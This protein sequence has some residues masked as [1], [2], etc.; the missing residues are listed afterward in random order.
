[1]TKVSFQ[2][3]YGAYSHLACMALFPDAQALPCVTFADALYAVEKGEATAAVIPLENSAAGRVA[4]MHRLLPR[5]N[6]Y[7]TAE[8]YQPIHHAL[9]GVKG[10]KVEDVKTA[11]SHVQALTQCE[12]F[13]QDKE[14]MPVTAADTAGSAQ[15]VAQLGDK[16]CAAIASI[17]AAEAYGLEV[18]AEDIQDQSSNTT[19]FVVFCPQASNAAYSSN[20]AY[21]TS[22]LFRVRNV[23]AALYKALGGFATNNVNILKLESYMDPDFGNT[24]FYAEV[25]AHTEEE[26]CRNAL[27]E[28]GFFTHDIKVLGCY[29]AA[30]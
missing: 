22:M 1:M 29:P 8:H 2:G 26:P 20:A 12:K 17:M 11:M 16:S 28:L 9:L 3:V 19:R 18:L 7:I 30:R 15:K 4:D 14:I 6:L 21:K 5:T 13:L 23:P 25:A 24:L 10:A 27:D